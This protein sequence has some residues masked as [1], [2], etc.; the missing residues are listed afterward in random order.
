MTLAT[1]TINGNNSGP[2]LRTPKIVVIHSTRSTIA[3]KTDSEELT[4]TLNWFT[5]PDGLS[6]HWVLSQL[7]RVRVVTDDL[8]AWHSA[9]LNGRSWSIELT[10]PTIDRPF[11][12]GHY[13]NLSLVGRRYVSLGVAPVWLSYWDGNLDASG[14]VAHQD[15][16]QGRESGK[17]DPGPEFDH[18]RFID[19]LEEDMPTLE[20]IKGLLERHAD[21]YILPKVEKIIKRQL[22]ALPPGG[23]LTEEEAVEAAI[24]ALRRGT[25]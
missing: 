18:V 13:D 14:F 15:T 1:R 22:D 20:E 19:S 21:S 24:E 6:A 9:W 17:T 8:I 3:T 12:N 7:E 5:N 11:T 2:Y 16:K 23:G 25:G 4:S 10:Q